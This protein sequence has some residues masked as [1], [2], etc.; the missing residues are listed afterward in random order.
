MRTPL[1]ALGAAFLVG[2]V[3]L[4]ALAK[5]DTAATKKKDGTV[6]RWQH[7]YADALEEARDRGAV[8]F[9]TFH[10]DH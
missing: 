5:T 7:S 1:A 4:P 6:L 2:A 10:I 8:I 9:A 3:S